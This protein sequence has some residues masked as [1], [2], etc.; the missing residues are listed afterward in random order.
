MQYCL[1]IMAFALVALGMTGDAWDAVQSQ[2]TS[3]G[4]ATLG[5]AA[6]TMLGS[7]YISWKDNRRLAFQASQQSKVRAI[8]E[9]ELM[10]AAYRLLRPFFL[11]FH[12]PQ[13]DDLP[14][15][16]EE[17]ALKDAEYLIETLKSHSFMKRLAGVDVRSDANVSPTHTFAEIFTDSA[18]DSEEMFDGCVAKY[19]AY[20]GATELLNIH[21]LMT[22]DFFKMRL[23]GMQEFAKMN[24][25]VETNLGLDERYLGEAGADYLRFIGLVGQLTASL[26]P[27]PRYGEMHQ[28]EAA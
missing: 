3:L 2:P 15:I 5:V 17:R 20:L 25:D 4:W 16:D 19:S 21:Y 1:S 27:R 26:P 8:A 10:E 28:S 23:L 18:R 14:R 12:L 9:A 22:S 24:S 11:Y 13:F 6:A 7:I